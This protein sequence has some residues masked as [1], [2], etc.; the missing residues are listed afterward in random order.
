MR[1]LIIEDEPQAATRIEKLVL[2]I[3]P[4][5]EILDKLDTVKRTVAWLSCHPAPDMIL[6][7]I[8]LADGLSFQVFDQ[9]KITSPV[10]FTTAFDEYAIKAF[11]VNGV[12]YILKPV[13]RDEL[14]TAVDKV[15]AHAKSQVTP[16]FL[17]DLGEA[18]QMLGKKYKNRFVIKV[19][20]HLRTIETDLI[21]FFYSQDKT[22]FCVT[23]ENR[24]HILDYTLEQL[25][26]MVDPARFFRINRK[27]MVSP[28]AIRDII[29]YSNSRLR[30][31]L[32]NSSD[33]DVIVAREKVLE[34]KSWLDQ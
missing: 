13:D 14:K 32:M 23:A 12:D 1:V 7:D 15:R 30:L 26:E 20:E 33:N 8:Q 5:A 28:A 29:S 17:K 31:V 18:M 25:T 27:Y 22:T 24:S 3:V 11:K 4:S 19:G 10:V 2:E 34:F 6:M 16:E 21:L 9:W